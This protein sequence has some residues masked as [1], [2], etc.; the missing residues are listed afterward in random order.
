[1][2][3]SVIIFFFEEKGTTMKR[4][5]NKK[6]AIIWREPFLN[7]KKFEPNET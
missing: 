6:V 7:K 2:T 4:N 5:S 3:S 1:L